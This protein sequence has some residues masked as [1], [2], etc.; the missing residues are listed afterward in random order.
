MTARALLR[1]V[2]VTAVV[3]VVQFTLGLDVTVGGAHPDL[4]LLLAVAAGV[5]GGPAEGAVV[6]F[7]AGMAA[8]LLLPTPFGLSALV[9]CLVGFGVG[10]ATGSTT[11]DEWWLAAAVALV[12]SAAG[13]L[14]FAALGAVV[15]EGQFFKVDLLAVVVV[16]S[17]VNAL[18]APPAVRLFSRV[19]QAPSVDG[20]RASAAGGRW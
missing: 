10:Y 17:V 8:D 14:L 7:V 11:R 13:V 16:V 18:L 20:A 19:L 15:G 4:M 2:G 1:T 12:A 6:G 9:G 5:A 3:L